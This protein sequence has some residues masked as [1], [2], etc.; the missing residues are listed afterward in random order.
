MT[1]YNSL[2]R[3]PSLNCDTLWAAV[4][5]RAHL[6]SKSRR[7][8]HP[9]AILPGRSRSV[10]GQSSLS[11][12]FATSSRFSL[13]LYVS[14]LHSTSTSKCVIKLFVLLAYT[15]CVWMWY[16]K[17]WEWTD[18]TVRYNVSTVCKTDQAIN[19]LTSR[20]KLIMLLSVADLRGIPWSRRTPPPLCSK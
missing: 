18:T 7:S 19:W 6:A 4:C 12:L 15:A 20:R 1:F 3:C 16:L 10:P 9:T 8:W 17:L 2:C 14:I 13:E 5:L 11:S